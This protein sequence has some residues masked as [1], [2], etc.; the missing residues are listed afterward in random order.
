MNAPHDIFSVMTVSPPEV[1][2]ELAVAVA[3]QWWG[4]DATAHP[5]RGE[6]D[7]NFH[8]RCADGNAFVLKFANPAEDADFRDM[9]IA[10]L[11]HVARVDPGLMVPRIIPRPDGA[12][13]AE[14]PRD[15]GTILRARLLSFV[16]GAVLRSTVR[17]AAQREACGRMLARLQAAL[18][19]F[20]HRARDHQVVWDLQHTPLL[21]QIAFAIPH[22][23]ARARVGELLD[24][25]D[26][27]V[28]PMLP[29]LRRQM[30]HNDLNDQNMLADPDDPTRIVGII[31]FGDLAETAVVFD[32]A[33]AAVTQAGPADDVPTALADFVG[34]FHAERPLLPEEVALLPLLM[35]VRIAM[36]TTLSAWHRHSQPDNPHFEVTEATIRRRLALMAALHSPATVHALRR[37]CGLT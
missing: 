24:E 30:L 4:I 33:I 6:R 21:R 36:G 20:T 3:R 8:L 16:P 7:S 11:R 1:S 27:R 12:I 17:S 5:L 31:D 29:S 37:A 15:G 25:F 23:A 34:G 14:L 28:V 2:P 35:A 13:Q 32:V 10:A 19:G 26:R 18:A 22:D 9:Q